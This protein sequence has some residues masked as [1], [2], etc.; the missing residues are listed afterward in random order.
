MQPGALE[1]IAYSE[2]PRGTRV[3]QLTQVG[4]SIIRMA[5]ETGFSNIPAL[6]TEPGEYPPGAHN[7][8]QNLDVPHTVL[9]R[10]AEAFGLEHLT[11]RLSCIAR[12]IRIDGY[13]YR[14]GRRRPL[15]IG[16]SLCAN[17]K[18][19]CQAL[20]SQ[21]VLG[22]ALDV[23]LP[24]IYERDLHT[25]S[26]QIA[27]VNAT[28]VPG[29]DD[30]PLHGFFSV[31]DKRPEI[32]N[33]LLAPALLFRCGFFEGRFG[34]RPEFENDGSCSAKRPQPFKETTHI[35]HAFSGRRAAD[36][37]SHLMRFAHNDEILD[38]QTERLRAQSLHDLLGSFKRAKRVGRIETDP[39]MCVRYFADN[40]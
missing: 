32:T 11:R 19:A 39:D 36:P 33:A 25:Y 29:A 27:A 21:P 15:R 30:H 20:N 5:N 10:E 31:C 37:K 24:D 3:V 18:T 6:E 17:F 16:E 14:I 2:Q 38:M 12:R 9:N 26:R 4:W 35:Q 22:D 8:A 23:F 1:E 40:R 28:H 34:R 13:Q 7:L